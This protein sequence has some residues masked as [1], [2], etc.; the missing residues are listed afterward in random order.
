MI[1]CSSMNCFCTWSF[2]VDM[3]LRLKGRETPTVRVVDGG[4]SELIVRR[5]EARASERV[6]SDRRS[7]ARKRLQV[8]DG[9]EF[10]STVGG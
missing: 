2:S 8:I 1:L 3:V 5:R 6:A 9:M 7:K 10:D 4:A